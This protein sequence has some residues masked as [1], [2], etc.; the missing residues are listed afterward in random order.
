MN[1]K[2]KIDEKI[3]SKERVLKIMFFR[4]K[5]TNKQQRK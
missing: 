5:R 2:K 3:F 4:C 1:K